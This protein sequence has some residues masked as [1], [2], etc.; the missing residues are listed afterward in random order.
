MTI[1]N[2]IIEG[3]FSSEKEPLEDANRFG[4]VGHRLGQECFQ[5]GIVRQVHNCIGHRMSQTAATK[6]GVGDDSDLAH[7]SRTIRGLSLRRVGQGALS[8][9]AS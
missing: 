8:V 7:V 9:L 3:C 5:P 4:P 1:L 2:L 6:G